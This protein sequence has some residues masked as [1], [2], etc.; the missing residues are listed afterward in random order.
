VTFLLNE[1][2][3]F[4]VTIEGGYA[5]INDGGIDPDERDVELYETI[6]SG[7]VQASGGGGAGVCGDPQAG[8]CFEENDS[9]GCDDLECCE[10]VCAQVALCCINSWIQTCANIANDICEPPPEGT[11]AYHVITIVGVDATVRLDGVTITTGRANVTGINQDR[12]GGVFIRDADPLLVQCTFD[13]NSAVDGGA[14]AIV[15]STTPESE[16]AAPLLV[17]CRFFSNSATSDGGAIFNF[18]SRPQFTNCVFDGNAADGN[19]GAVF[20]D[21][22][23]GLGFTGASD[24]R[25][26]T[27]WANSAVSGGGIYNSDPINFNGVATVT[28]CIVWGNGPEPIVNNATV[29]FSCVEG[30]FE[31]GDGIIDLDP[32]FVDPNGPDGNPGDKY[33]DL[34]LDLDES[35]CIDA[36]SNSEIPPDDVDL[37]GDGDRDEPTPRDLVD[38]TRVTFNA[39]VG[40]VCDGVTVD[41]GAFENADCNGN[42]FRDE[43]EGGADENDDGIPDQCQDCNDNGIRDD[44]EI[45]NCDNCNP[46]CH[47][48]N[49]NGR[50][51]QCDLPGQDG[52]DDDDND[53]GILD[54]CELPLGTNLS[55][56]VAPIDGN[57]RGLAFDGTDLYYTLS[58][59]PNIYQVTTQGQLTGAETIVPFCLSGDDPVE[60]RPIGALA[61]DGTGPTPTLWAATYDDSDP[62]IFRVDIATG[63]VLETIDSLPLNPNDPTTFPRGIDGLAFDPSDNSLFY[64]ADLS[65]EVFNIGASG[66]PGC[67]AIVA[68]QNLSRGFF[69]P[70]ADLSGHAF[71]GTFLYTGQATE[72]FG[73]PNS[74]PGEQIL[75]TLPDSSEI[76]L[77][78]HAMRANGSPFKAED[79]AFDSVTFASKCV[80]WANE[81]TEAGNRIAAF[82][83]PC[84]CPEDCF[85]DANGDGVVN[86]SD[87]LF[88]LS[89]WGP[90]PDPPEPCP[91]DLDDNGDVGITDF[92]QLLANWGCPEPNPE[93]FP[94][95]AQRCIDRYWPNVEKVATCITARFI[96]DGL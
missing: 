14:I 13:L 32:M 21:G 39:K 95:S 57:G 4:N 20:T 76:L 66:G 38:V 37:D 65:I 67:A 90:C 68:E 6:L 82:E 26:C 56:F 85:A 41:L 40:E 28:N 50:P 53:N 54:S 7:D 22:I 33:D 9:P 15:S 52:C 35:P 30:G 88:M 45:A 55:E 93:P 8:S 72:H 77:N 79:L 42:D 59:D 87:F 36:G 58:G 92:L 5:G 47:D 19:G 49:N 43:I 48:C 2:D 11:E 64:S 94:A 69:F 29:N 18:A 86:I 84:P 25:S 81:A 74:N 12:G 23:A 63:E 70:E 73:E 61:F 46:M 34:R 60:L 83:V 24:L 80:V 3:L 44:V 78:F 16:A 1:P 62:L 17:N 91:A 71:D 75:R 27:L 31:P 96:I 10:L 51:D 89:T